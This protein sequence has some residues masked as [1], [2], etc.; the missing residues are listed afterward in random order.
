VISR[1]GIGENLIAGLIATGLIA[2][3][4]WGSSRIDASAP[5]WLVVLALAV[6][7]AIGWILSR[8]MRAG[9][10][11]AG[12]QAE[13]LRDVVLGLREVV[14]GNI[15]IT[16]SDFVERGVLSP[17][18]YG[19]STSKGEEIRLSVLAFDKAGDTFKMLYESGH[20]L[21]R[22]ANFSLPKASLAGH[23]LES[24]KLEWAGDVDGDQRWQ[25][26]GQ[27]DDERSY[28]SLASMPIMAGEEAVAVL[29]VVS[30]EKAAFLKGDLTY[31]EL[32][33]SFLGLAWVAAGQA[34]TLEQSK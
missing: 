28:K 9:R 20:S 24:Q 8:H 27:A 7:V 26:H 23:A 18:R 12:Y 21:G 6:G 22:K 4:G 34:P 29:N 33:G 16:F 31:I 3:A 14:G 1:R 2:L 30:S 10:D 13:H 5:L 25:P 32:L 17:A 19:L 15:G 11:L